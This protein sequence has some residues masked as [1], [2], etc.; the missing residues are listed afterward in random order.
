[1][2]AIM[3][4]SGIFAVFVGIACIGEIINHFFVW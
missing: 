2:A 4:L 3:F 1:M